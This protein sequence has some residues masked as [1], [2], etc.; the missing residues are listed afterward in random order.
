MDTTKHLD[1]LRQD[2]R[3]VA[4]VGDASARDVA[5]RLILALEPALRMALLDA[6]HDA[7]GEISA[8][9]SGP[10][11]TVGLANREPV[12]SVVGVQAAAPAAA[13]APDNFEDGD[14]VAR[15]TFRLPESLKV[16][17][18]ALAAQ[19]GQSLNTWLVNAARLAAGGAE[20]PSRDGP[21]APGRNRSSRHRI[22]G[23]VR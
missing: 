3:R 6:L 16:R 2:L 9:L 10:V 4:E 15:I 18:E 11:V 7:A 14:A 17:A 8:Q 1:S 5:E 22:Q 19:R 21:G 20:G 23:W 13:E 12:F